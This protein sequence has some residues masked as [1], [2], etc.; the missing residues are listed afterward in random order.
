MVQERIN[1]INKL[2]IY[3]VADILRWIKACPLLSDLELYHNRIMTLTAA[4]NDTDTLQVN[5]R[6]L[7]LAHNNIIDVNWVSLTS[8]AEMLRQLGIG[9]I[10]FRSIHSKQQQGQFCHQENTAGIHVI[11]ISSPTGT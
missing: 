1:E 11:L 4:V 7:N 6:S 8:V 10:S 9:I 5:L 3:L 2:I